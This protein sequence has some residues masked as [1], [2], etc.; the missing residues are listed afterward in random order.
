MR[1]SVVLRPCL[2]TMKNTSPHSRRWNL[3]LTTAAGSVFLPRACAIPRMRLRMP[4]AAPDEKPHDF[5]S[6]RAAENALRAFGT[7]RPGQFI[8]CPVGKKRNPIAARGFQRTSND[9]RPNHPSAVFPFFDGR[10][11]PHT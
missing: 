3:S 11:G 10:D 5:R 2:R 8:H 7:R 1:A 9:G 4:A 6:D